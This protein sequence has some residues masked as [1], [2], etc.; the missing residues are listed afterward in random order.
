MLE[1]ENDFV[2]A[3]PG[4]QVQYLG[5]FLSVTP[6]IVD[7]NEHILM[8]VDDIASATKG[9]RY[10]SMSIIGRVLTLKSLINSKLVYKWLHYP[11]P[12]DIVFTKMHTLYYDYVWEGRHRMPMKLMEYPVEKG[13]FNM[14]NIIRQNF[15]LKLQW[16]SKTLR[17][18]EDKAFWEMYL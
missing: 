3:Q 10:Q 7:I 16:I 6:Q 14:V 5:I 1:V 18:A 4:E 12:S 11:T 15:S 17:N 9:L 8:S 2:W 13:G